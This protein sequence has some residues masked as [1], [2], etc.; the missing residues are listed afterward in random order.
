M[1]AIAICQPVNFEL[2]TNTISSIFECSTF[3]VMFDVKVR[4]A[5]VM[6]GGLYLLTA[7]PHSFLFLFFL[8][9]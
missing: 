4:K 7:V 8:I 5:L 9:K 2:Q 6:L 1:R 3:S